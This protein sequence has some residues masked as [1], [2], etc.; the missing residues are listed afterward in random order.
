MVQVRPADIDRFLAAP[1]PAIR[2]VLFYGPDEGLV[3]ERANAFCQKVVGGSD[4]PFALVRLDSNELAENPGRLADEANSVPLFGG[5]RA[6][7]LRHSGSRSIVPSLEAILD[8]PPVDSWVAIVAGELRKDSPI[9][10]LCEKRQGAA[11]IACYADSGR[12]LDRIID[13]EFSLA[14]LAISGEARAFLH[15][16]I[17][18]DRLASRSEIRK[19]CLYAADADSVSID[20]VRAIVG[21]A[22]NFAVDE[23]VDALALGDIDSFDR[24]YRRLVASGT[25]GFVIAG[26]SLRHFG[27]LHLSRAAYDRGAGAKDIV[28]RARPPIFFRRQPAVEHQIALW[29]R[30]RIERA[31]AHLDQA[32]IES[33]FRSAIADAVIGQALTLV[34]TVAASLRRGRA[35]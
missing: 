27:F 30:P 21:D 26:A 9:R 22:S 5:Q 16:L 18:S 15:T 33:R 2:L 19:L 13:E 20:D 25:P 6:V 34:A 12:D 7:F 28:G 4:D 10:R 35:A 32:V 31:L 14:G 24:S 1:D 17:G 23:T 3:I 11:A 8:S 29:P